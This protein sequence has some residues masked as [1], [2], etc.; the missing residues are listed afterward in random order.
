M[1]RFLV[2]SNSVTAVAP[3][4]GKAMRDTDNSTITCVLRE[5]DMWPRPLV[6]RQRRP[7]SGELGGAV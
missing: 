2:W 5:S 3:R 4:E 6:S 7:R 1:D